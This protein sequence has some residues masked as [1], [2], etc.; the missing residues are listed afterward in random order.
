MT[1]LRRAQMSD[2]YHPPMAE[3]RLGRVQ[4][5]LGFALFVMMGI[6]LI[7]GVAFVVWWNVTTESRART[8]CH[9]SGGTFVVV[10]SQPGTPGY[11]AC[12]GG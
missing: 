7:C 5:A 9:K 10:P 4:D 11:S 3:G 2:A 1:R 12:G 8:A 6:A